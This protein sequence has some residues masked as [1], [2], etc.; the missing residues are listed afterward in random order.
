MYL[1]MGRIF[2][3]DGTDDCLQYISMEVSWKRNRQKWECIIK[4]DFKETDFSD[5]EYLRN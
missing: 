2:I 1:K 4:M 5:V 3:L